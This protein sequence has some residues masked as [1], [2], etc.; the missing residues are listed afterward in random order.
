MWFLC[1]KHRYRSSSSTD[2][3]NICDVNILWERGHSLSWC[4]TW[5]EPTERRRAQDGPAEDRF[6]CS[7]SLNTQSVT[8]RHFPERQEIHIYSGNSFTLLLH[9]ARETQ[10]YLSSHSTPE[11]LPLPWGEC[12]RLQTGLCCNRRQIRVSRQPLGVSTACWDSAWARTQLWMSLQERP[13][14][15]AACGG[16]SSP[17]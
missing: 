12:S 17:L 4:A 8:Y 15:A 2:A 5:L 16:R 9:R 14:P 7:G 3:Q 11:F 1:I 10:F 13:Q 6:H